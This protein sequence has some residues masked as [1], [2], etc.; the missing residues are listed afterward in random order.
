MKKLILFIL[1]VIV[2]VKIYA[3]RNPA[4]DTTKNVEEPERIGK[5]PKI[6]EVKTYF[7]H[8]S[9]IDYRNAEYKIEIW[10]WIT[11]QDTS[12]RVNTKLGE[13]I[14]VKDAKE[15][16]VEFIP[17][18]PFT[19]TL[20]KRLYKIT[21]TMDK[22]WK[23]KN[24]PFD[25]QTL[26]IFV[27]TINSNKWVFLDT[28]TVYYSDTTDGRFR[29][30]DDWYFRPGS[31]VVKNATVGHV[32]RDTVTYAAINYVIPLKQDNH[33]GLFAKLFLGMYVAVL[34]AFIALFIPVQSEEPRF[35]LPVGGL[36]AAIGNKYII[37]S[38]LPVSTCYTLVDTL[39]SITIVWIL[40]VIAYSAVLLHIN[41][42]KRKFELS[43]LTTEGT[44][45]P[46]Y[47]VYPSLRIILNDF[48]KAIVGIIT[49]AY[50]IVNLVVV[51]ISV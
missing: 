39:H 43:R 11:P 13:Q 49:I 8:I 38:L 24:F 12:N 3:G 48:D 6:Y 47:Y 45:L 44:G 37:E 9:D 25:E 30:D 23:M 41:N 33:W 50:L 32:F 42:Q 29:V 18:W 7:H 20:K 28:S 21:C 22:K 19:D 40:I 26:D 4:K 2:V 35:G 17:Q 1:M 27:Y 14:E 34:V 16:K 15:L 31:V 10:L 36:F 5:K 51:F 46:K